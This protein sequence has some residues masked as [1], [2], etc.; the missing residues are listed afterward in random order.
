MPVIPET[1]KPTV[2]IRYSPQSS[3]E[4]LLEVQYGL[5][6]EGVPWELT[7]DTGSALEL[8]WKAAQESR[9]EVGIG[10]DA[11]HVVLH[12]AKLDP[13]EPLFSIPARSGEE[14]LRSIGANAARLVK[15]VP[16]KNLNR[17]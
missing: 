7:S 5:E 4:D 1:I 9:L 15:K 10:L 16:L 14:S 8:A 2:R 17:R 6:E 11:Q 3:K 12:F 13:A